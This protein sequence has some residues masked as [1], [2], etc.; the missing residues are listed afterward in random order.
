MC[1]LKPRT[2]Q[3]GGLQMLEHSHEVADAAS[4]SPVCKAGREPPAATAKQCVQQQPAHH[5]HVSQPPRPPAAPPPAAGAARPPPP[6]PDCRHR[7]QAAAQRQR[8][9]RPG[10]RG[11]HG[12]ALPAEGKRR[13]HTASLAAA[14]STWLPRHAWTRVRTACC[15][16]HAVRVMP[17]SRS[18]RQQWQ[19]VPT[20][21]AA[22]AMHGLPAAPGEWLRQRSPPLRPH[23]LWSRAQRRGPAAQVGQCLAEYSWDAEGVRV[24]WLQGH[25]HSTLRSTLHHCAH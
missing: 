12:S 14:S 15:A 22:H 9:P 2:A 25:L 20:N 7:H 3:L 5:P 21:H 23:E 16:R 6:L 24:L 4:C 13:R 1:A 19:A 17:A 11:P 18:W 10:R 8:L